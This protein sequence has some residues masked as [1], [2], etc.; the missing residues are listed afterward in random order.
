MKKFT[1]LEGAKK[2]EI[3]P[4]SINYIDKNSLKQYLKIADKFLSAAGKN[5]VKYLIDHNNTYISD[6]GSDIDE[7]ALVA[8]YNGPIP[9][10]P[11][12]KELYKNIGTVVK[13]GRILEIPVFQTKEQ[14]ESIIM[15]TESPDSVIMDLESEAGRNMV[16][17]KYE[18]LIHKIC[19][20]W[21][22]K[23]NLDYESLLSAAYTGLVYAMN[24]YGKK[25]ARSKV[26]DETIANYSFSQYAAYMIRASILDD[27]K[28]LSHTVRIPISQQSKERKDTGRNTKNNSISGDKTIGGG[29]EGNSKTLFDT[30]GGAEDGGKSMDDKDIDK[31]WQT[32]Y[33]HLESKFDKTTMDIWYSSNGLNGHEKLKGKELAKKY[34]IV[35]SN[36]N[37]YNFKV[38]S[39]IQKN[40]KIM[41]LLAQLHE[42][43]RESLASKD[44]EEI[45]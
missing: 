19:R 18:P 27:I 29:D 8:F 20:Q 41:N 32:L 30:I 4:N 43:T 45:F 31:L 40:P 10:D 23:S 26:D 39:Y 11:E 13:S 28:N 34:G 44:N 7:N 14:F 1:I 16:T 15:R 22:G 24:N 25:T 38:N 21:L 5:V 33:K 35:P 6:L 42:L 9:T 17:K 12:K 2:L 37:Y 36:V 3:Q